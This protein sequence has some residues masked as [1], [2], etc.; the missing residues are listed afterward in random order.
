MIEKAKKNAKKIGLEDMINWEI[1][2]CQEY[3]NQ[4]L[5]GSMVANPPY[6][7]RMTPGDIDEI[8]QTLFTIAEKNDLS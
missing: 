1:K 7:I 3:A 6:G 4:E 2:S 5:S 8:H